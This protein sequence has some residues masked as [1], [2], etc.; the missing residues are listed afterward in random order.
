LETKTPELSSLRSGPPL[1]VTVT[2]AIVGFAQLLEQG[3][4]RNTLSL[5]SAILGALA[6]WVIKEIESSYSHGKHVRRITR[7][8]KELIKELP[9]SVGKR[10]KEIENNIAIC[11]SGLINAKI[12]DAKPK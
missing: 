5:L 4:L 9:S 10:R 2:T 12:T 8:K 6:A 1:S 11:D 7:Y 3:L